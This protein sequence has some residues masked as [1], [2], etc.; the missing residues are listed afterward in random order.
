VVGSLIEAHL[1]G[2]MEED[3]EC[4]Y[5]HTRIDDSMS[6]GGDKKNCSVGEDNSNMCKDDVIE[7]ELI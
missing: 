1:L 6:Q 2:S 5:D 7:M 4:D 3:E